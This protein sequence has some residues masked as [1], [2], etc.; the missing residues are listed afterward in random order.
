[1]RK[2]ISLTKTFYSV[3]YAVWGSGF[4]RHAWF[5]DYA[6]AK[7]FAEEDYTDNV[8]QHSYTKEKSIKI[9]EERV[10]ATLSELGEMV[11]EQ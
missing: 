3:V 5:D 8:V 4:S 2:T 7:A 1:M 9:A 6:K 10:A 11:V